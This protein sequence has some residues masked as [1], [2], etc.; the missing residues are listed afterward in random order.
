MVV[1]DCASVAAELRVP[2]RSML[3]ANS[4]RPPS[5][6][7]TANGKTVERGTSFSQSTARFGF[8]GRRRR[9]VLEVRLR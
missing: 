4:L 2:G 3:L 9:H 5:E 1:P 6:P 7:R 8:A